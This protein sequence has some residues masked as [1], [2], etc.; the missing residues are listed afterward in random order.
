MICLTERKRKG[1]EPFL[2]AQ[3]L[4][5]SGDLVENRGEPCE[6]VLDSLNKRTSGAEPAKK[7]NKPHHRSPFTV[8]IP[9]TAGLARPVL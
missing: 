9:L 3:L 8:G 6:E 2:F 7:I 4:L 5:R 1:I